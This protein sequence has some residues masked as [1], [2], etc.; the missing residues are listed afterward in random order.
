[1]RQRKYADT[2]FN[3][4]IGVVKKVIATEKHA[5]NFEDLR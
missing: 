5:Q 2:C 4:F 1:M 3:Y